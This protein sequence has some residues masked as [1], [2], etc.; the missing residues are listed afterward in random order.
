MVSLE[1]GRMSVNAGNEV[2]I[3]FASRH[4]SVVGFCSTT[5]G[6][7]SHQRIC[8]VP[9]LTVRRC[10]CPRLEALIKYLVSCFVCCHDLVSVTVVGC[11][12]TV[13]AN[14]FTLR[15]LWRNSFSLCRSRVSRQ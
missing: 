1:I 11:C 9:F 7:V 12:Q 10:P 6:D 3:S 15:S 13:R 5:S 14:A 4:L 2:R 8:A